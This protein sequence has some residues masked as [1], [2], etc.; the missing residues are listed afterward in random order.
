[1]MFI[2]P[3]VNR[4]DSLFQRLLGRLSLSQKLV[5][6][7]L[8]IIILPLT[9]SFA[10]SQRIIEQSSIQRIRNSGESA[11]SLVHRNIDDLLERMSSAALFLDGSL[12]MKRVIA[13]PPE[14][15]R[16]RYLQASYIEELFNGIEDTVIRQNSFLT[17][18]TSDNRL[19]T[20][21]HQ[22]RDLAD[23]IRT[24][25]EWRPEVY[26]NLR[27][28]WLG[29]N[30]VLKL[31][32]TQDSFTFSL[33]KQLTLDPA[34]EITA[35]LL[36]SLPRSILEREMEDLTP[37]LFLLLDE[38]SRLVGGTPGALDDSD[39]GRHITLPEST[40]RGFQRTLYRRE[41]HF[42]FRESLDIGI[43]E[44]VY[45]IP[46]DY[47]LGEIRRQR[48]QLILIN[49]IFI[50]IFVAFAILVS[51]SISKPIA[52]LSAEMA[53]VEGLLSSGN[54]ERS[55]R[56][57]EIG[58]LES[59]FEEMRN[60]LARLIEENSIKEQLKREA[61][62]EALQAQI[63]PHFLFNTL[64]TIRWAAF[65]DNKEKVSQV[66]RSLGQLLRTTMSLKSPLISLRQELDLIE[67]Y[68][69]IVRSR[70]AVRFVH[71]FFVSEEALEIMIPKLLLQPLVENAVIHGF[72]NREGEGTLTISGEITGGKV[73]LR[74]E[75]DGEGFDPE[76]PPAEPEKGIR[77]SSIGL[78]N[79]RERIRLFFGDEYSLRIESS[80]GEGT[81]AVVSLPL[82][83]RA[84][85]DQP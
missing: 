22:H 20:N 77:F 52:A 76:S 73:E 62:L 66:V 3:L 35:F 78:S 43:W 8:L 31:Y 25:L 56:Q 71:R 74:I 42:M 59:S 83:S 28:H 11:F 39:Y 30:S 14:N 49:L 51:R 37:A 18:L 47:A 15:D 81:C 36:I 60:N 46:A 21:H 85:E 6:S 64:N 45:L 7:F 29:S 80:P 69:S 32:D 24:V 54:R 33:S 38:E 4:L 12:E 79:I 44:L 27:L 61:E 63:S 10:I 26:E 58:L 70:H 19:Y 55:R 23:E 1:M 9:I 34:E 16:E 57:D 48:T 82:R 5:F 67:H 75:D 72:Q 2:D 68:L 13:A 84:E 50:S 41:P 53:D 17:L 65:N 40:A